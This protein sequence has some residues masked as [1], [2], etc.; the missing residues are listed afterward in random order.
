MKRPPPAQLN[1]IDRAIAVFAPRVAG[2]RLMARQALALAG[3]YNGARRDRPGMASSVIYGGSPD[4]DVI[5]DLPTLR[6]RSRDAERNQPVAAS[7]IN[8][9]A[10]HAVGTG[11][12]CNPRIDG[13]FLGMSEEE[14]DDWQKDTRRRYLAWFTSKD[15][16]LGRR[17]NGYQLQDLALRTVLSSGDALVI[18]PRVNRGG[19][20]AMLALQIVEADRISNPS[21]RQDSDTLT[22]GVECDATTGEAVAFHVASSHPGDL[23]G[24]GARSWQR[25]EA[26]GSSG[27]LNALHL[28]KVIRPGL[29]RGVPILAPVMEPIKQLADFAQ[30]ELRAAVNSAVFAMFA[31]I[32]PKAFDETFTEEDR[33]TLVDRASKWSGQIESGQ[34]MNLLPGE[35]VESP[36]PGRPNPEFDPFFQACVR[37]IGMAIG[38]PYEVLI[39]HYQSSYSAARGALLMAWRFFMSWRDWLASDLCQPV[40]ELWL[41]EE[42]ANGRIP[43]PGFFADPVVRSAWCGAQWVGDG[44]G[45]IDPQKEVGAAKERVALGISTLQAESQLHDGVDWETKHQQTIKESTARREAGLEV[46]GEAPPAPTPPAE[47]TDEEKKRAN[48]QAQAAA[49]AARAS[50]DLSDALAKAALRE[51][52]APVNNFTMPA[53]TLPASQVHLSMPEAAAPAPYSVEREVVRDAETGLIKTSIDRYIPATPR[54][55]H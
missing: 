52:V 10:T 51:P 35:T 45:S 34:V 47:P 42:V 27:R 14:V 21:G 4:S 55:E 26:R 53:I 9:T 16:D 40:Y 46:A 32:D 19:Y 54:K 11:L 17:Q 49:N 39:M 22:D 3:G 7:V 44:P 8:T 15:C 20:G 38:I 36:T 29:R 30:A 5:A 37:Q 6:A 50:A 48:E 43:A 18:T 31:T 2:R 13:A 12:T 28:F 33:Q 1:L 24:G 25:V 23:R 41:S